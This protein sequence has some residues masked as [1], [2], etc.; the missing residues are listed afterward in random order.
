MTTVRPMVVKCPYCGKK[1][2]YMWCSSFYCR[3]YVLWSDS[4][5]WWDIQPHEFLC[6]KC[7]NIYLDHWNRVDISPLRE[8]FLR[9]SWPKSDFIS[10]WDLKQHKDSLYKI[11]EKEPEQAFQ[12]W[13]YFFHKYNTYFSRFSNKEFCKITWW[14]IQKNIE[15]DED[16]NF[17]KEILHYIL[18]VIPDDRIILKWEIFRELWMFDECIQFL[19]NAKNVFK[20][21]PENLHAVNEIIKH[22]KNKDMEV[23]MLIIT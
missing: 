3:E 4:Y 14:K 1:R 17:K 5:A 18:D 7:K 8:L 2:S 20:G 21:Q 22:A 6:R 10:Y 23:F 13:L 11:K 19:E 12:L 9:S 16:K 15:T